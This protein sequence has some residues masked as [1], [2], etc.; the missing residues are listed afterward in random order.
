MILS[1]ADD[2]RLKVWSCE[3]ASCPVTLIGHTRGINDFQIIDKGRNIVSASRDGSCKL[4]DIGESR[5]LATVS[6]FNCIINCISLSDLSDNAIKELELPERSEALNEREVGTENKIVA[7]ACEDGYLRI[8]GLR[9]RKLLLEFKF[10]SSVNCCCF[11]S[12]TK[13]VCGTQKGFIHVIDLIE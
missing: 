2:F 8:I 3:D 13:V 6:Q 11:V 7:C 10:E 9:A 1:G 4:F 12:E 5:C